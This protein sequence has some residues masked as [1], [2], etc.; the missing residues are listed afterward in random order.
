MGVGGDNSWGARPHKQYLIPVQKYS[1]SIRL[2]PYD[3][4]KQTPEIL[5]NQYFGSIY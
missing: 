3:S 5:K 4:K 1:Y 2:K